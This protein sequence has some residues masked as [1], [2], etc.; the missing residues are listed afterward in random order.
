L[1]KNYCRSAGIKTIITVGIIGLPNVGKSSIINSLK[2]ARAVGVGATPGVTKCAQEVSLDSNIKLLD[3]P[4][5]IFSSSTSESEAVLRNCVK[6]EQLSDPTAPVDIILNRCKQQQLLQIYKIPKFD[7][8]NE[9]LCNV[10][11]KRGKL[12]PG[13]VE[14]VESAAR[15]VLTD[16]TTGKIPYYTTPPDISKNRS[17]HLSAAVVTEW[18][19]AFDLE[20]IMHLERKQIQA[21]N[22]PNRMEEDF[23]V[24]AP[25]ETLKVDVSFENLDNEELPDEDRMADDEQSDETEESDVDEDVDG[26]EEEHLVVEHKQQQ[27]PRKE[28]D[29][30]TED[31][32]HNPQTN[33]QIRKIQKMEKKQKRKEQRLIIQNLPLN[34]ENYDF[35]VDF[36]ANEAEKKETKE[37][38]L[39]D[40]DEFEL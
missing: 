38:E 1:L 12:K 5:I 34:E 18:S 29:L 22:N 23:I 3:C 11:K 15:L 33:Q 7:N 28:N 8:A 21:A 19:K 16:W 14:D 27:K 2:R 26:M 37:E 30:F 35:N 13:G 32:L 9:F 4:G 6:I 40:I 36:W 24:L 17:V 25:G 31:D 10:A 20:K 39:R